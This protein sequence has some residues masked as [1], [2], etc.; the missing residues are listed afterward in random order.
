MRYV[1]RALALML[2][3]LL[4]WNLATAQRALDELPPRTGEQLTKP[5][6]RESHQGAENPRQGSRSDRQGRWGGPDPYG[7]EGYQAVMDKAEM[8][9]NDPQWQLKLDLQ[10][11]KRIVVQQPDGTAEE[12]WY[13]MFRV[14]NDNMR[15]IK[16]TT[17]P[18]KYDG[19]VDLGRRIEPLETQDNSPFEF[20]GV[21]VDAHLDFEFHVFSR[22]IERDPWHTE[23]P[24]EPEDEVLPAEALAQRRANMKTVYRPV[25]NH[26][27]LQRIAE[28]EGMYEWMD[29]RDYINEPVMLLHPLSDFQR[30]VGFAHELGA[31]DFSG[32]RCLAYRFVVVDGSEQA[33]GTRYVAV[34]NDNT[35]AGFYGQGD[36]L[37]EG[38]R[39]VDNPNDAMW[40]KLT[41]R[42]YQAGDS[43]DRYGRPL[44]ANDPGY[45]NA[46]VA[47]GRPDDV[48]SYGVIPA[49]HP[50]VGQPVRVPHARL[51]KASDRVLMDFDTGIRHYALPNRTHRIN[52][53]VVTEA[54]PRFGRAVELG[55]NSELRQ[56]V[57]TPVKM[58]D[59]R[60]RP[61]RRYVVTY[62]PGDILTQA[63]WDIY[64]R[65][66]GPGLL[67]RYSNVGDIVGRPL[68]ADD[69]V[70]GMPKIKMGF[71]T[72][73]AELRGESITRGIDTGRR[74]PEGEVIL[75][76]RE[77]YSTG[78]SYNAS[79]IGP[80][81]FRQDI[82]G[83]FTTNRVAPLP[84]N[85]GL[86]AGEDYIYAPLGNAAEGAMP[87]P[88][89]DE[90]GA[91]ADY[92]DPISD[93][94]IP[95]TDS[96]GELVRDILDQILY[97]KSYEYE[98][99]YM[100][101]FERMPM[102]DDGFRSEYGGEDYRLV[103][104]EVEVTVQRQTIVG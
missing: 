18:Q 20:E 29:N 90:H 66:I 19:R 28:A 30:Q 42:R 7:P 9:L 15:R 3:T 103:Q 24:A 22:D 39:L 56:Y 53:M 91:W 57:G 55:N 96:E 61:I 58:L 8:K 84:N 43:I 10:P 31:S 34:Y 25:S 50:A 93:Q 52:G 67:S 35:F 59:Q 27:V 33:S 68:T 86:K 76:G 5:G 6:A 87:V 98:Y 60:G 73:D 36:T 32:P 104:D 13:V 94:R 47:G 46:R 85:H 23:Y 74:G 1:F 72:G 45:L 12:Y 81:H 44:R 63:E 71:F 92:F 100:Y 16:E 75:Q 54:D 99:V 89:F 70:V 65:R 41:I 14:I 49:D 80:E 88:K 62:Q 17:P 11:P 37:P 102:D 101:E 48:N 69:P 79:R 64:R 2:A 21:P 78:R 51:H 77:G 97:L 40:G 26:Y 38:A 95:V 4:V 83:E 82:D